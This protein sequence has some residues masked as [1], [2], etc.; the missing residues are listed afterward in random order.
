ME[1]VD[2]ILIVDDD[3]EI[4]ELV[5]NYLK[6]NGLR[7]EFSRGKLR[8]SLEGTTQVADDYDIGL[9]TDPWRYPPADRIARLR[10]ER[11]LSQAQL[12]EQA[13]A[14]VVEAS[15]LAA[16]R[17]RLDEAGRRH[18]VLPGQCLCHLRRRDAEA[19]QVGQRSAGQHQGGIQQA[20][21]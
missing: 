2:H 13:D 1:H 9:V 5:G 10:L 20:A 15:E 12:A 17:D 4:R 21:R 6:K 19:A 11:N 7:T 16:L 18:D 14:H 3:R 8:A